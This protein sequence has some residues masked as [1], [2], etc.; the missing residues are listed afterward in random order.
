MLLRKF[1]FKFILRASGRLRLRVYFSFLSTLLF[2]VFCFGKFSPPIERFLPGGAAGPW[3]VAA[4]AVFGGHAAFLR[5]GVRLTF[6]GCL[7]G[8]SLLAGPRASK[9]AFALFDI[10]K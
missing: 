6:R 10:N 1:K 3:P 8:G 4:Y 7:G 5:A 2:F 9:K